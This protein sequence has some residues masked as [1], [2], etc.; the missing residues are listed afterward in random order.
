MPSS[1]SSQMKGFFASLCILAFMLA[2]VP[3]VSSG[4]AAPFTSVTGSGWRGN[5]STP[6]TPIHHF[7]VSAH[8]GPEGVSGIYSLSSPANPLLDFTGRVTCLDVV[9]DHAIVGGVVTGGGEPGQIGTGFAVGFIDGGSGSDRQTFTDVEIAAPVDCA[10]EQ[11]LF[12]LMLFPV[13]NG[14]VVVNG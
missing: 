7:V 11:S 13:L 9:G 1:A 14:N 12:T 4:A 8:S 6:T 5:I 2:L 10:A 3:A